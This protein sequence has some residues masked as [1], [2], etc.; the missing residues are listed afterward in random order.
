MI[1]TLHTAVP[2][3]P[4][5]ATG[6]GAAAR[7]ISGAAIANEAEPYEPL[8]TGRPRSMANALAQTLG[9]E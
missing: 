9:D 7:K 2:Y 3:R 6:A 8:S 5:N 1:V 4:P